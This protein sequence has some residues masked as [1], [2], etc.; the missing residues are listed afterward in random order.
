MHMKTLLEQRLQAEMD[1]Q[2]RD[3]GL[4]EVLREALKEAS[5]ILETDQR[6]HKLEEDRDYQRDDHSHLDTKFKSLKECLDGLVEVVNHID[7]RVRK[8][9]DAPVIDDSESERAQELE[10]ILSPHEVQCLAED[11]LKDC[12]LVLEAA[13]CRVRTL[14]P[15]LNPT[16]IY[17]QVF[18]IGGV[19]FFTD[20]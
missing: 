20:E 13:G 14:T 7:G 9:E 1:E 17:S 4:P 15:L 2:Q 11:L 18:D 10:K 3:Q 5:V 19:K 12:I 16:L 8:L 6:I